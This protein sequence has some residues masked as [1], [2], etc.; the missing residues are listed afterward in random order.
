MA[1]HKTRVTTSL[2]YLGPSVSRSCQADFCLYALA[3]AVPHQRLPIIS[4]CFVASVALIWNSSLVI[5]WLVYIFVFY[6]SVVSPLRVRNR[7]VLHLTRHIAATQQMGAEWLAIIL[8]GKERNSPNS[9]QH[10]VRRTS[11]AHHLPHDCN[12]SKRSL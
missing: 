8:P 2:H 1:S 10:F 12:Q 5:G 11:R 6:P 9:S 7:C 4:P 3:L